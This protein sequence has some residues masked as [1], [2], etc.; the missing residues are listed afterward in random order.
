MLVNMLRSGL[1]KV[2]LSS[3]LLVAL[4]FILEREVYVPV[5]SLKETRFV[6]FVLCLLSYPEC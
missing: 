4:A 1:V 2:D 3:S 5:R 6:S